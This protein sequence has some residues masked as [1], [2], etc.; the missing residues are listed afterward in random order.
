MA[1]T[2]TPSI[3][4]VV[5]SAEDA[6]LRCG[7]G[8]VFYPIAKLK[9]GRVLEVD[10]RRDQWLRVRLSGVG[11][12]FVKAE[13]V[14]V[15]DGWAT[16]TE[17][18]RLRQ[19]NVGSGYVGS[20]KSLLG[21]P[22]EVGTRLK[23]IEPVPGQTGEP[24]AYRVTAPTGSHGF[25]HQRLVRDATEQEIAAF[26]AGAPA[27]GVNA[28][29]ETGSK[30]RA[31]ASEASADTGDAPSQAEADDESLLEPI[32][33]PVADAGEGLTTTPRV[34]NRVQKPSTAVAAPRER[35][36]KAPDGGA[37]AVASLD[38][39]ERAFSAVRA[40]KGE[41][42]ELEALIGQFEQALSAITG[43]GPIEQRLRRRVRQRIDLLRLRLDVREERRRMDEAARGAR[44]ASSRFAD[45]IEQIRRDGAYTLVGR[46]VPSVVYDGTRLPLMYRLRSVGQGTPRTLGYLRPGT[47]QPLYRLLGEVVGV[48]GQVAL[49][50]TIHL[51]II[52]PERVDRIDQDRATPTSAGSAPQPANAS[53][54]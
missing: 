12:A 21:D 30:P 27:A 8:I 10:G 41:D 4:Y 7:E 53:D 5:V 14:R 29:R 28:A 22:L 43:Q 19:V 39:L 45:Q 25:I 46:L 47:D 18:T 37:H 54:G 49:D 6:V 34:P 52:V 15:Q 24:V 36:I 51:R 13:R 42:A 11:S 35:T 20:W 38:D 44:Q 40:Q 50:P 26:K 9:R 3:S 48:R 1:Q 33:D 2:P 17:A 32:M 23:I 16:L 31:G